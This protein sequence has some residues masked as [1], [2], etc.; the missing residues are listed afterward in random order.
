MHFKQKT[1]LWNKLDI[2]L[3]AIQRVKLQNEGQIN[4]ADDRKA[5]QTSTIR[6]RSRR[7]PSAQARRAEAAAAV[8][9]EAGG[10]EW[11]YPEGR[12]PPFSAGPGAPG[13]SSPA[14]AFT[15]AAF[16]YMLALLLT[17]ALIFFAIWHVSSRGRGKEASDSAASCSSGPAAARGPGCQRAPGRGRAARV[18]D[19]G[20]R[21]PGLGVRRAWRAGSRCPRRRVREQAALR[22]SRAGLGGAGGTLSTLGPRGLIVRVSHRTERRLSA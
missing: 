2:H 18:V 19:A 6:G 14:M 1:S 11:F 12:A 10:S 8:E 16:C 5:T 4:S 22:Y 7:R 20:L 9:A 21:A 13:S 15:F 17:A 3:M